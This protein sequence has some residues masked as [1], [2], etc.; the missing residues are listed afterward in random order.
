MVDWTD[1]IIAK[2]RMMWVNG[3]STAEIGRRLNTSKH[4]V[5]GKAHRLNLPA[6]PSPIKIGGKWSETRKQY[7][8]QRESREAVQA[9]VAVRPIQ[10]TLDQPKPS[11]VRV[12]PCS[13]VEGVKGNWRYCDQP[14]APGR[15]YCHD[16]CA[17]AYAR[18]AASTMTTVNAST[19]SR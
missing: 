15:V 3:L 1:E 14:S 4:A 19:T 11:R 18:T 6:R 9:I 17:V 8:K 10:I 5:I 7:T 12:E 16:H 2:L 13:W